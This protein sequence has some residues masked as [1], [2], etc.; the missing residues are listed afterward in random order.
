MVEKL[1]VWLGARSAKP[2]FAIHVFLFIYSGQGIMIMVKDVLLC[3][4]TFQQSCFLFIYLGQGNDFIEDVVLCSPSYPF[5]TTA[6]LVFLFIWYIQGK[7]MII[8]SISC[9][10]LQLFFWTVIEFLSPQMPTMEGW[11]G[12][13]G[14]D[15]GHQTVRG[16][17]KANLQI[18]GVFLPKSLLWFWGKES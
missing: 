15:T 18:A 1:L 8:L 6:T 16:C 17:F 3:I 5:V 7:N 14:G 9:L 13:A 10:P 2:S 12:K 11:K 4:I